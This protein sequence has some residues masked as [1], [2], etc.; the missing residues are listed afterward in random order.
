MYH[1]GRLD[2]VFH[3]DNYPQRR[4]LLL[5]MYYHEMSCK[6]NKIVMIKFVNNHGLNCHDRNLL[7]YFDHFQS[8]TLFVLEV[9]VLG[10]LAC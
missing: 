2:V 9:L 7:F 5:H 6:V 4:H 1:F 10:D 3:L 8:G